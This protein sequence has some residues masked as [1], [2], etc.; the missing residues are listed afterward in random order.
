MGNTESSA[1]DEDEE[2]TK[3]EEVIKV[4]QPSKLREELENGNDAV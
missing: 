1:S 4:F 2:K 3:P